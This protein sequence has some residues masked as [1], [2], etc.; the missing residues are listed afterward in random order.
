M[1]DNQLLE[2]GFRRYH[3]EEINVYF[4]KE[5]CEHAAECVGNAPEVFD[6]KKRPWITPDEASALKVERTVKLC[7]SGALQYRYDN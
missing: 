3:G 5:I 7:P 6:T 1:S 4:N 2:R